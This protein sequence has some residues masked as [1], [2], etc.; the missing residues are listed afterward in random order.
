MTGRRGV[1][2]R[3]LSIGLP[4]G[5]DPYSSAVADGVVYVTASPP[6]DPDTDLGEAPAPGIARLPL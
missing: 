4:S 6:I 2:L 3:R 5:L 1:N